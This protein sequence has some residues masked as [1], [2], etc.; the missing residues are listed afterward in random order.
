MAI[1]YPVV[2]AKEF[3]AS[4]T[5]LA[6]RVGCDSS[7]DVLD[8]LRTVPADTLH[9]LL[10]KTHSSVIA[11]ASAELPHHVVQDGDFHNARPSEALKSGNIARIPT[12]IGIVFLAHPFI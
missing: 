10:E 12:I 7:S 5:R 6:E 4:Y 1:R 11:S 9:D 2:R 8:C 3:D